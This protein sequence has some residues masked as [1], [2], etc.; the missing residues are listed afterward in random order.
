MGLAGGSVYWQNI[1]SNTED[2]TFLF[3]TIL[4]HALYAWDESFEF[5][6]NHVNKLVCNI[7]VLVLNKNIVAQIYSG[8]ECTARQSHRAHTRV[9]CPPSAPSALSI[10]PS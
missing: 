3:L 4:W 2:P 5:L 8:A 10:T 9:P 1:F 7:L 6:Y